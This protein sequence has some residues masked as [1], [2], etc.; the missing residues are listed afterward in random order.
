VFQH[1][2]SPWLELQAGFQKSGI[3]GAGFRGAASRGAGNTALCHVLRRAMQAKP[4]GK[5]DLR[6]IEPQ[7]ALIE[8]RHA[9]SPVESA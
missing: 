6:R 7:G 4:V 3:V 5:Y 9:G 8:E 1:F 2:G